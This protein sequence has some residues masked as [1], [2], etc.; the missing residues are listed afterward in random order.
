M[1]FQ[2]IMFLGLLSC[3]ASLTPHEKIERVN[4]Y[5]TLRQQKDPRFLQYV[6]DT[7]KVWFDTKENKPILRLKVNQS[8]GP[9]AAWDSVMNSQ[10]TLDSIWYNE[11]QTAVVALLAESN[12][13]YRL[14]GKPP[15]ICEMSFWFNSEGEISEGLMYWPPHKNNATDEFLQ[16]VV[17]WAYQYDSTEISYLYKNEEIEPSAENAIRWKALLRNYQ[18]FKDSIGTK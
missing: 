14:L 2:L 9:W 11:S 1:K 6:A 8:K 3:T 5:L 17:D 10:S 12:D 4:Q 16:P 7:V 15:T 18:S 13:F